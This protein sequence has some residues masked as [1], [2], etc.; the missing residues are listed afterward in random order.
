MNENEIV[1]I[2]KVCFLMIVANVFG[3]FFDTGVVK[4]YVG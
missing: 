4:C 2:A 1:Y 3:D